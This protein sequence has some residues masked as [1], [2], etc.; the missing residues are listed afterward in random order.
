MGIIG[1]IVNPRLLP[2]RVRCRAG[3]MILKGNSEELQVRLQHDVAH[4]KN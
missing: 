1:S 3:P 4:Y 2:P